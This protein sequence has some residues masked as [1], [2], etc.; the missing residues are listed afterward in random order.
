MQRKVHRFIN[1]VGLLLIIAS[2]VVSVSNHSASTAQTAQTTPAATP[3]P[4]PFTAEITPV[5]MYPG[6]GGINPETARPKGILAP[7]GDDPKKTY[8]VFGPGTRNVPPG[9][10]VYVQAGAIG[11]TAG[12]KLADYAWTLAKAPDG[13]AAKLA[14]VEQAVPGLS[15]EMATFTPDKEGEYAISLVVTDD[16][17]AKSAAGAITMVAAR[18]AGNEAC[19][20][21]HKEQYEGWAKTPHGTAFER[22][23]NENAE[24]EYF[25]AGYGCAR[26]HTV[27]YYPVKESTGG[28]WEMLGAPANWPKDA[29]ALNAFN[30]E[31]GKD[32]FSTKFDP[33][34]QAVS[35]I[36]CESCHGPAGAHV[37]APG[38]ETAPTARADSSSCDQ[39]H[40]A[41][42]HH[43]R[44]SAA[45]NSAHAKAGDLTAANGRAECAKCHSPKGS[46]ETLAGEKEVA[47][48]VGDLG[49]PVCHDPHAEANS[50]QLRQV[51]A[52]K[53]PTAE[54]KDAGLSAGC[55]QCHNSNSDPQSIATDKPG[56]PHYSSA[57]ELIAGIGGYDFGVKIQNS[58]H[59]NI[60]KGVLNDEHTNQPGNMRFTQVN[61]GKAPGACVLCHMYRTPGGVW[62]TKE[63]LA[64]PGHQKIGGHAFAMASEQDGKQV[65]HTA[66]CQ[67]CHAGLTTFDFPA[68]SDY[69]GNGKVEGV[70]TEV[71]GLLDQLEK[72]ILAKGVEKVEG[73]PYFKIPASAS[74]EVKGAIYNFRYVNGVM[75][76]GAGKGAAAHNFNRAVGLLQVSIAKVT[77]QDVPKAALLY[78]P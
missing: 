38:E 41:G 46:I 2:V 23:I 53:I 71:K 24:G 5:G 34:V 62:D 67:Q 32:T 65:E 78:Q 29:I 13:S 70:Q 22:Y 25:T 74:V 40:N 48:E 55:I 68:K 51:D 27:G 14:K 52:V 12:A 50:F 64:T 8:A 36:G 44:G 61:D 31:K 56:Y 75:W 17:G 35:N 9:V 63:S 26:C 49:C 11:I 10:P 43:T 18:Y 73:Y 76:S 28:W 66:P 58:F 47:Q 60:G 30:E 39:C 20:D 42:G 15:L 6:M 57:A 54:I 45:L 77:G 72:A 33:K 3:T 69:D 7:R 16:K 4:I 21:C 1:V 37:A 59:V 19:K